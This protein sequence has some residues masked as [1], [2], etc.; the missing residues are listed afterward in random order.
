M[1]CLLFCVIW[2][3]RRVVELSA[4]YFRDGSSSVAGVRTLKEPE[5]SGKD[6]YAAQAKFLS[7]LAWRQGWAYSVVRVS[8]SYSFLQGAKGPWFRVGKVSRFASGRK[9][10]KPKQTKHKQK[11]KQIKSWESV[12]V[13][14]CVEASLLALLWR[15]GSTESD[16]C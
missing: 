6:I 1:A 8:C 14:Q 11:N 3:V 5:G 4:S 16:G 13:I 15:H 2:A 7:E 12:V 9:N 10:E